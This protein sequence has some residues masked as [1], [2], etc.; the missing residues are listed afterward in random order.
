[1][2]GLD[3]VKSP[4]KTECYQREYTQTGATF[5]FGGRKYVFDMTNAT[6]WT[7]TCPDGTS[8]HVPGKEVTSCAP[9][10]ICC[11]TMSPPVCEPFP[12]F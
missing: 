11:S 10:G 2:G 9:P 7:M 1:M 12:F 5:T 3:I 8:S 6:L 4:T